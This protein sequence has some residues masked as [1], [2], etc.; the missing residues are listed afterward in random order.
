MLSLLFLL[1]LLLDTEVRDVMV[2]AAAAILEL[3]G[4]V[5]ANIPSPIPST[6]NVAVSL[7]L[8]HW[9]H[10]NAYDFPI[11]EMPPLFPPTPQVTISSS[12]HLYLLCVYLL[13][14][15]SLIIHLQPSFWFYH[16]KEASHHKVTTA[17]L[18]GKYNKHVSLF[19][20]LYLSAS[21]DGLNHQS[22]VYLRTLHS[23][24]IQDSVYSWTSFHLPD[25]LCL[26]LWAFFPLPTLSVPH[27]WLTAPSSLHSPGGFI[28]SRCSNWHLNTSNSE[29]AR[30]NQNSSLIHTQTPDH[31]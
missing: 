5:I 28:L 11:S 22:S 24:V 6:F 12:L 23:F 8:S 1:F 2:R 21:L 20:F 29:Y 26:F 31:S 19:I 13:T 4:H 15:Y 14:F 16:I 9:V 17:I 25:F 30:P 7:S 27:P 3:W 10:S 18:I